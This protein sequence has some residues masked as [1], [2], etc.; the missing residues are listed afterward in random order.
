[1]LIQIFTGSLRASRYGEDVSGPIRDPNPSLDLTD[2]SMR[3]MHRIRISTNLK[4]KPMHD[5][6]P[7]SPSTINRRA[8]IGGITGATAL[9]VAG[10][11]IVNAQ[12]TPSAAETTTRETTAATRVTT[13]ISAVKAD[14]DAVAGKI[15]ATMVD[16]LLALATDLQATS[17]S[18]ATPA[19]GTPSSGTASATQSSPMRDLAAAGITASAAREEILAQLSGFGLPSQQ[20]PVSKMLAATFETI[21]TEG[22]EIKTA[23]NANATSALTTAQ[24]LYT[25]AHDAYG[26][27]LYARAGRH[28]VAARRMVEV[29]K[30]LTGKGKS[31]KGRLGMLEKDASSLLKRG[32]RGRRHDW[33]SPVG[34]NRTDG[35]NETDSGTPVAVPDPS[36]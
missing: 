34:T 13:L 5:E 12:S 15:D 26:T 27:K 6:R 30:V 22:A 32:E 35:S 7:G 14:R 1:M 17:G 28:D 8:L 23:N 9:A 2:V 18:A 11:G 20:A 19:A 3:W 24:D 33:G 29:A 21:T 36:F 25:A 10:A 4:D 16:R 31:G